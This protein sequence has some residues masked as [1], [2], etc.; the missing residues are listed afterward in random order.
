MCVKYS[1]SAKC[2]Y[3]HVHLE[4]VSHGAG[5]LCLLDLEG[6][7]EV[8][9]PL[10]ALLVAVHPE[11]VHLAQVDHVVQLLRPLEVAPGALPLHRPVTV[12][13]RLQ[14]DSV[15]LIGD[16]SHSLTHL[17]DEEIQ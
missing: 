12:H 3:S 11:E 1:T 13:D 5:L 2:A 4:E 16:S 6:G 17:A 15:L 8:D 9:E 10:E 7:E 14:W